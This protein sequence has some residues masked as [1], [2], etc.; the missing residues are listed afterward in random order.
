MSGHQAS[1]A[2][3]LASPVFRGVWQAPRA[4]HQLGTW[5]PEARAALRQ[6]EQFANTVYPPRSTS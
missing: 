4:W 2:L 5:L 3:R 1:V 6:I